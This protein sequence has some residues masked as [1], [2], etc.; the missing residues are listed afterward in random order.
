MT[1]V[2]LSIAIALAIAACGTPA[3]QPGTGIQG[4]VQ[5]GPTCPVERIN[6]PCPPHPMAA[7]V[8]VRTGNGAEVTRF[9]SGPDGRFK[10][11]LAPGSYTLIGLRGRFPRRSR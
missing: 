1:R 9:H 8:V 3:A 2:M 5:V 7:T 11:D 4:S 6:S 10:V